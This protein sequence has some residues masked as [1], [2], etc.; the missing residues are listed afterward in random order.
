[1]TE[2]EAKAHLPPLQR[3]RLPSLL[4]PRAQKAYDQ[5]AYHMFV[6]VNPEEVITV[7]TV[8]AKYTRLRQL[9]CC[10]EI[11]I[12]DFGAG[13]AIEAVIDKIQEF[14]ELPNW[15]HN[16]IFTPFVPAIS[17]FAERL[18]EGLQMAR[19]DI[20]TIQGGMEA[21]EVRTVQETFR[22]N[23]ETMIIAS[24]KASQAWNAE[25]ALNVYF[26]HFD[27]DQD[28]NKQA[29]GRSRRADGSQEL[30]RAY[31]VS[32]RGTITEDMIEILNH[33]EYTNRLSYQD[34]V[35]LNA[36]LRHRAQKAR[37]QGNDH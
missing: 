6:E 14:D 27:W 33:K 1:V 18:S 11:L 4:S 12:E 35:K 36:K 25:T 2:N 37:A 19:T 8:L 32:F 5:M 3:I 24:L 17:I 20:L 22:R 31:Y 10:P 34:V 28:E 7:Q 13:D 15:K 9:I 21:D 16:I 29:E 30:I 26:P 23:Q